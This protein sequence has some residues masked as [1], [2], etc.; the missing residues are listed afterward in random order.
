[1]DKVI[2][3]NPSPHV[4]RVMINRPEAK[5]AIDAETRQALITALQGVLADRDNRA[6]LL[7][8]A[9]GMFCA[10]G[11]LVSMHGMSE[12]ESLSRM[13]NGHVLVSL[14]WSAQIPVVAAV[15]KYAIGAGAGLAL[16]S[17]YVVAGEKTFLSFPFL[18][19]G[20]VPDWG[21]TQM[22]I[23]RVGWG[24]ARQLILD[25]AA[26]RGQ[27][28]QELG[29]ADCVVADSSVLETATQKATE[30]SRFPRLPFRLFK[31]RMMAYPESFEKALVAEAQDQTACFLSAEFDEGLSALMEKREAD[32]LAVAGEARK[33]EN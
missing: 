11:D 16:L 13:Q 8:G 29:I 1:M 26:P 31:Q 12:E 25:K 32:F 2:V 30:F 33:G 20:L 22:L 15:E 7:C 14:L 6:L 24:R 18:Q 19:I 9:E 10:G 23:R 3:D 5:N 28:L 17:D 27:E 4:A 21:S